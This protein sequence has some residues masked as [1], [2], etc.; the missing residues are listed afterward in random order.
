VPIPNRKSKA[1]LIRETTLSHRSSFQQHRTHL[2]LRF[3]FAQPIFT[4]RVSNPP[5][6]G[7][8][9]KFISPTIDERPGLPG[10]NIYEP[11][12]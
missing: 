3:D 1:F 2:M 5:E 10:K 7:V 11:V 4:T 9:S 12:S 8:V 6:M